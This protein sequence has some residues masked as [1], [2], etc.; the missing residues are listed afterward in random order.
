[1]TRT[2]FIIVMMLFLLKGKVFSQNDTINKIFYHNMVTLSPIEFDVWM[3]QTFIECSE[4]KKIDTDSI[5]ALVINRINKGL[6]TSESA[7]MDGYRI[8][9]RIEKVIEHK[10]DSKKTLS[11]I[12]SVV[13]ILYAQDLTKIKLLL[14]KAAILQEQD[15]PNKNET[16]LA[17]YNKA[18]SVLDSI[19]LEYK[20][21]ELESLFNAGEILFKSLH[22]KVEADKYYLTVQSFPFWSIQN[23]FYFS[24]YRRLYVNSGYRRLDLN[25][26]NLKALERLGFV[27]STSDEL[28]PLWKS[29]IEEV[30]GNWDSI[31]GD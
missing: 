12:E 29:Y 7:I 13:N 5:S 28:Y 1:M 16:N 27:P 26:G 9:N 10:Y 31:F 8:I 22:N 2:T 19:N 15:F 14:K 23:S 3:A 24:K 4:G 18:I 6:F 11:Y 20:L 30:G 21:I 25:R 17:L